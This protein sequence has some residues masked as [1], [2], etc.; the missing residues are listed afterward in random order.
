MARRALSVVLQVERCKFR[1]KR[2]T[3]DLSKWRR[4]SANERALGHRQCSRATDRVV[5]LTLRALKAAM[6]TQR[7]VDATAL[8]RRAPTSDDEVAFPWL[9]AEDALKKFGVRKIHST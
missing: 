8:R 7:N 4:V 6:T 2:S 3:V 1:R 9:S 5:Y